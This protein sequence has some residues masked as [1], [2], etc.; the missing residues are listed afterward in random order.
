MADA[1]H[2][3][4]PGQA[5]PRPI[6]DAPIGQAGPATRGASWLRWRRGKGWRWPGPGTPAPLRRRRRTQTA[7]VRSISMT[8]ASAGHER[9]VPGRPP[10]AEAGSAGTQPGRPPVVANQ[11]LIGAEV[12]RAGQHTEIPHPP[13]CLIVSLQPTASRETTPLT[14]P[15]STESGKYEEDGEEQSGADRQPIRGARAS[16][17]SVRSNT[18][19]DQLP[20]TNTTTIRPGQHHDTTSTNDHQ[21]Q[22]TPRATNLKTVVVHATVGSNPTPTAGRTG[23]NGTPVP[24][25]RQPQEFGSPFFTTERIASPSEIGVPGPGD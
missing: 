24:L 4:A 22:Q 8:K 10:A 6:A 18:Q 12:V 14:R 11:E 9:A 15:P 21:R 25:R 23:L 17:Q 1:V 3:D 5:A 16:P 19:P 20:P 2:R 7:A 13:H